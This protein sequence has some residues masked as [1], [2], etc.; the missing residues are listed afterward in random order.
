M[1]R[2]GQREQA[3][4]GGGSV[5][6]IVGGR[7][8]FP[9]GPLIANPSNRFG[10]GQSVPCLQSSDLGLPV[11]GNDD[12]FIHTCIDARFIEERHII[13]DDGLGIFA[14]GEPGE[15]GL[16]TGDAGV[17]DLFQKSQLRA[18]AEHQ[19]AQRRAINRPIGIHD[20]FS[21]RL[22]DLTPGRLARPFAQP[23]GAVPIKAG[24]RFCL[25]EPAG[26]VDVGIVL[27]QGP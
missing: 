4:A 24:C 7:N 18:I 9:Q 3:W 1:E 13:Y 17:N 14:A 2:L 25:V 11:G 20:D 16:F 12:D 6:N 15:P 10:A 27:S 23:V 19:G 26:A 21:E 22:H 5:E 8:F